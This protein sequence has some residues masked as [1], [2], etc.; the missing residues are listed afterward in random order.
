MDLAH[1]DTRVSEPLG[2]IDEILVH[3]ET[4]ASINHS[5]RLDVTNIYLDSA[6][7]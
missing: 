6:V 7:R 2:S 4:G 5:G 1:L 3:L